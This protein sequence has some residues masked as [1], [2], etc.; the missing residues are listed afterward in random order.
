MTV[1]MI[2]VVILLFNSIIGGSDGTGLRG[3]IQEQGNKAVN[4]IDT[5]S[6]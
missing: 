1:M 5:L 2:L 4:Q 6:P 3:E